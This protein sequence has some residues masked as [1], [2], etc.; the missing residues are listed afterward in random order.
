MIVLFLDTCTSDLNI[1]LVKDGELIYKYQQKHNN[2]HSKNTMTEINNALINQNIKPKDI[3]KIIVTVGPGSYTGIRIGLTIAK[4][5]AW[6]LN[7]PIIPAS[8]LKAMAMTSED[9][10]YY[11]PELDARRGYVYSAIYDSNYNEIIPEQYIKEEFLLEK[12]EELEGV[13][14]M[15]DET[16]TIDILKVVSYYERFPSVNPHELNP[17]YLKRTEAEENL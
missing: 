6:S 7:I 14:N 3:N 2:E 9:A 8:S 10:D 16:A 12:K 4:T 17:V 13:T 1:G 5:L 11:I 15:I